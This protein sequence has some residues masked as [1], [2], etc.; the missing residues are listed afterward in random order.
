MYCELQYQC[1]IFS[2]LSIENEERMSKIPLKTVTF[3][4]NLEY[5]AICSTDRRDRSAGPATRERDLSIARHVYTIGNPLDLTSGLVLAIEPTMY[6]A[7]NRNFSTNGRL[8]REIELWAQ[9][10]PHQLARSSAI[11]PALAPSEAVV[12]A[13]VAALVTPGAAPVS[14]PASALSAKAVYRD[15]VSPGWSVSVAPKVTRPA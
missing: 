5:I 14:G 11:V 9:Y 4:R 12:A 7:P 10:V 1:H 13:A 8:G 15:T 3:N 2:E 6:C